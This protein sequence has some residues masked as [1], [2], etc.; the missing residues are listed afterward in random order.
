MPE[1]EMNVPGGC[2]GRLRRGVPGHGRLPDFSP[3]DDPGL[4]LRLR[5]GIQVEGTGG[6]RIILAGFPPLTLWAVTGD[7]FCRQDDG[8]VRYGP[9]DGGASA[10]VWAIRKT[11]SA[12]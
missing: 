1:W 6:I 10:M 9:A 3:L 2:G 4:M 5:P 8:L 12:A 11:L 7:R